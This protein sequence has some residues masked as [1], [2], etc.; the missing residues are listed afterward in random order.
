MKGKWYIKLLL[1][2]HWLLSVALFAGLVYLYITDQT[3]K[4]LAALLPSQYELP[5]LICAAVV[6]VCFAIAAFFAIVRKRSR[7]EDRGFVVIDTSDSGRV[8]MAVSAIEQ[9]VR[10]AAGSVEGLQDMKPEI[11]GLEDSIDVHVNATIINGAHVPSVSLNLQRAIRQYV[12]MNC[13][14]N[15]HD[16]TVSILS[17]MR[18]ET[19]EKRLRRPPHPSFGHKDEPQEETH[20]VME[21]A[22]ET[23]QSVSS[24]I[25]TEEDFPAK[26]EETNSELETRADDGIAAY[27]HASEPKDEESSQ[28]WSED[29]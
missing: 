19:S 14:I 28:E 5:V 18:P 16:V 9:M 23:A 3:V 29:E 1:L 21:P 27:I 13:G 17:V 6:Y 8:R 25:A 7:R 15:V 12:E 24:A 10:E 4:G 20:S 2:I 22:D 11:V 26:N